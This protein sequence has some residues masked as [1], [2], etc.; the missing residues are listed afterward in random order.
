[1]ALTTSR[2][3]CESGRLSPDLSVG[4]RD[5]FKG[6]TADSRSISKAS[7]PVTRRRQATI[8]DTEQYGGT[9]RMPVTSSLSLAAKGDQKIEKPGARTRALELDVGYKPDRERTIST[10]CA[11]TAQG[12]FARLFL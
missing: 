7:T 1:M 2:H 12:P 11:T 3:R 5:F 4:L 10:G 6:T 9:F 8:K